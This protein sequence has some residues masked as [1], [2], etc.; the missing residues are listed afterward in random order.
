MGSIPSRTRRLESAVSICLLA[1]LFLIAV[2]I[3]HKQAQVDMARFGT[4]P[5]AAGVI[6]AQPAPPAGQNGPTLAVL[7]PQRYKELTQIEV[8][9]PGILYEKIDGKAPLYT[10]SGFVKLL[11]QR[12]V[13]ERDDS[14]WMELFVYDMGNLR[15][16]F[17]VYSRQRRADVEVLS[18]RQ[19]AYRTSNG[20]YFVHGR[21]YIELIG[22][23]ESAELFDAMTETAE[24]TRA[25]FAADENAE[26]TE[27]TFFPEQSLVPGSNRL[28]LDSAFGFKDLTDI[29]TAQYKLGDE[30]ITAFLGKRQGAKDAQ[31]MAG[32]YYD[33]LIE[34]GGTAKPTSNEILES[35]QGKIID[36]YG[37]TEIVLAVGPFLAGIHEADN[38]EAAEQLAVALANKLSTITETVDD[39][40]E[41]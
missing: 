5:V 17:S 31:A 27:L 16:A 2:G 32:K 13:S 18:T 41:R 20:L 35:Y 9:D 3:L 6:E 7:L 11:T 28:Y 21:Y 33:F 39:D 34:N 19:F 40:P 12:F 22:S 38:R 29:F 1:V 15:N 30:T 8:Y 14:L 25:Q 10:E 4:D 26:I 24:K 23:A 37:T 36:F